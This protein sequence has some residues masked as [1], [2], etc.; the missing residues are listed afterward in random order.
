L[1]YTNYRVGNPLWSIHVVEVPRSNPHYEIH[2]MH[3]G[4][5]A[6]GLGPLSAQVALFKPMPGEPAA[7]INGDFYVREK[8]YAGAPRGLQIVEGEVLSAPSGGPAFWLDA[9]GN[10]HATNVVSRF[11]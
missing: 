10:P 8:A 11:Q 3:A 6:L 7:A 5:H 2:S 4:G 1:L 9:L